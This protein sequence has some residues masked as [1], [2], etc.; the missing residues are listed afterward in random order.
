MCLMVRE[1]RQYNPKTFCDQ[2]GASILLVE[3]EQLLGWAIERVLADEGYEVTRTACGEYACEL[4][5]NPAFSLIITDFRLPTADGLEIT[6]ASHRLFPKR[7]IIM[8][9]AYGTEETVESALE[10]GASVFLHKPFALE[11]LLSNVQSLLN[12][13]V[14][15]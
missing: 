7:P 5:T 3:D 12:Q 6:R 15:S 1:F 13:K 4:L 14:T 2:N 11:D 8:M 10:G 9:S